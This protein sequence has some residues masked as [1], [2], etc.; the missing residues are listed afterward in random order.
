MSNE[1]NLTYFYQTRSSRRNIW[2][3]LFNVKGAEKVTYFMWTSFGIQGIQRKLDT[4]SK[5]LHKMSNIL[6]TLTVFVSIFI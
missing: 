6:F 4:I 1:A 3:L 5:S 2:I